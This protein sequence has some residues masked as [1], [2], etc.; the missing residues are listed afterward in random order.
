MQYSFRVLDHD[1]NFSLLLYELLVQP[2]IQGLFDNLST[3][4]KK[5][6]MDITLEDI[7]RD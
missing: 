3:M 4:K 1:K 5:M 6:L 7:L 2:R